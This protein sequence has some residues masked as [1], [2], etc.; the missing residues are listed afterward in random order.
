VHL[1]AARLPARTD[2]AGNLSSLLDRD[3]SQWDSHLVAAG[4]RFLDLSATGPDLTEYHIEA[5][6]AWVHA[7]AINTEETDWKR[8]VSLYELLMS[9]RPSP[10]VAL[11]RA[12]AIGQHEGG[13]AR[14]LEELR[15]IADADRLAN[16]PFY[17]AALVEFEFRRWSYELAREQFRNALSLARSPTE[18]SDI[19]LRHMSVHVNGLPLK[20]DSR[21]KQSTIWITSS[22]RST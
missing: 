1:H 15:A 10:V 11:N 7:T 3:Q 21:Q 6:I 2:A 9:I 20:S 17:F 14:S 12:I 4:Q 5:A 13:H 22:E 16:Y 19:F 8:I 18:R